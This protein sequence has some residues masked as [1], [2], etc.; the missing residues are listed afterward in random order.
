[1]KY[2]ILLFVFPFVNA[3]CQREIE[4][5]NWEVGLKL[6]YKVQ[7][8]RNPSKMLFTPEKY[9]ERYKKELVPYYDYKLFIE[10]VDE[11]TNEDSIALWLVKTW[12]KND[13]VDGMGGWLRNNDISQL[14][15]IEK[16]TGNF[17]EMQELNQGHKVKRITVGHFDVIKNDSMQMLYNPKQVFPMIFPPNTLAETDTL[18]HNSKGK[19]GETFLY[20]S[21]EISDNNN[22]KIEFREKRASFYKVIFIF[23]ED[24][25]FW[26]KQ[27]SYLNEYLTFEVT[28]IEE[29]L[30]KD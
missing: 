7:L 4:Y 22:L 18:Y 6:E 13:Y 27:Y 1:M 5:D 9:K 19:A 30:E 11:I 23:D 12:T 10:V 2:L 3:D 14:Y 8:Y 25:L 28:L 29:N 26:R 21:K 20:Y 17:I 24:F 15:K 16:K